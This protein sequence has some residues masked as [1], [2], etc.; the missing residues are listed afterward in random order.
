MND[1]VARLR[2]RSLASRPSISAERAR[3]LTDFYRAEEG[4]H[5][6]PLMRALSF[7][8]LCEHKTIHIG[9]DELIV[10]ERGPAPLAVP[11]FPELTCHTVEDLK[12]LD[13]RPRTS[14][15]V[16]REVLDTYSDI[17]IPYW[18]GRSIRDRVF[19]ELP[20]EWHDAYAAGVFTEFMEQRAPGHTVA[21]GKIYRKGLRDLQAEIVE[22]VNGFAAAI[23]ERVGDGEHRHG[24]P[25]DGCIQR[26]LALG[27]QPLELGHLLEP[28]L[29]LRILEGI[30]LERVARDVEVLAFGQSARVARVGDDQL[31]VLGA[32]RPEHVALVVLLGEDLLVLFGPGAEGRGER[33]RLDPGRSR[34]FGGQVF[35]LRRGQAHAL[36]HHVLRCDRAARSGGKTLS[37]R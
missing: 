4:R 12:I 30:Q 10:G 17:V 26:R 32:E 23:L 37:G 34:V 29:G 20:A 15:A 21:D 19:P 36:G 8:H 28:R 16:D 3:L 27:G 1:R 18:K 5:P 11:T 6:T 22:R 9:E 25:V 13:T 2:D 14:Y 31:L 24:L 33:F 35:R 7:R